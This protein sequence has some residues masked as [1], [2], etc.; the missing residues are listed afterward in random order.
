MTLFLNQEDPEFKN[1][2]GMRSFVRFGMIALLYFVITVVQFV[3]WGI[4]RYFGTNPYRD[5]VEDLCV[6]NLRYASH[7]SS[8]SLSRPSCSLLILDQGNNGFYIH[9][10][11]PHQFSE[12][13][14]GILIHQLDI[15]KVCASTSFSHLPPSLSI[16]PS[17]S[18]A[19][20]L[21]HRLMRSFTV[22]SSPTKLN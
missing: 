20:S 12:T 11:S 7:C 21:S 10:Q 22:T 1:T 2:N 9:G 6:S 5:Y 8:L 15:E 17:V 14:L 4:Q 3:W 13:S 19:F 16:P 18:I